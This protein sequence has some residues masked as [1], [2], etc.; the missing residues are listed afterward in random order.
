[1]TRTETHRSAAPSPRLRGLIGR[2]A[3]KA[4]APDE[5]GEERCDLCSEPIGPE[6]RHLLDLERRQILCACQ[7]CKIL[8]DRKEAGGD[9]YRLIP[10]RSREIVDFD[11]D[12][13]DWQN[14][15]IPVDMAFFF[16]STAV[17]RVVAFYPSPM[18]AT[19]SLLELEAWE[20][21]RARNPVLAELEPD[22][23]ALLVNRARGAREHWLVPVDR[24]YGLVGL[25][26]TRWKG[27][28][29][30]EEVWHE[31]DRF[32]DELRGRATMAT[33]DGK[34]AAWPR[35]RSESPT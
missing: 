32:F 26:R 22:V 21:L 18:G 11:L 16:A 14:L 5:R 28:G 33:R 6:H 10:D 29:G 19:E 1:M 4:A 24:C 8:F 13:A 9:H 12:D 3:A 30:G 35:S 7:A 23:E 25:I 17:G 15:R 27:L 31:I 34:E 2:S 20:N